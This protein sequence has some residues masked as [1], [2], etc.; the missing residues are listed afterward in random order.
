MEQY[1]VDIA[2]VAVI[3]AAVW[4]GARRGLIRGLIAIAALIAALFGASWCANHLTPAVVDWVQPLLTEQVTDA[5]QNGQTAGASGLV[6]AVIGVVGQDT[7]E[8]AQQ[9]VE[10][11][12]LENAMALLGEA[13]RGSIEAMMEEMLQPVVHTAVFIIAFILL[14]I[15]LGLVAM[16]LRLVDR[17]PVVH[18]LSHLGGAVLG[19]V[20]GAVIVSVGLWACEKF[21]W[22]APTMMKDSILAPFFAEGAWL[23]YIV[24]LF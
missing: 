12:G 18:G 14:R 20:S 3:A 24:A 6:D 9:V 7:W 16:P 10:T 1:Y 13:G 5:L 21:A 2:I 19:A 8:M 11:I 15:L 22:V 17:L 4:I 23:E